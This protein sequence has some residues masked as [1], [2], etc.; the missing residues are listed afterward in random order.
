MKISVIGTGYV[1]LVTAVC[2]AKAGH[3]V[4]CLDVDKKKISKLKKGECPIY[5]PDL[6][7]LLNEAIKKG[8]IRF[9]T[10]KKYSAKF[11]LFQFL[12]VGTPQSSDGSPNLDYIKQAAKEIAINMDSRKIIVNKSTV[13]IGMTIS[14]REI[15]E[16][17][18]IKE[19]K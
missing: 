10:D 16:K 4:L 13:P 8:N 19:R 14:V 9:T 6:K 18:I 3:Q 5:E 7:E 17:I 2:F 15:F 11:G 12:C 1:G